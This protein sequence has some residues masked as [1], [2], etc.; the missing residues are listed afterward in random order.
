MSAWC[1]LL[2]GWCGE[3]GAWNGGF[4]IP[5]SDRLNLD[6]AGRRLDEDDRVKYV[7]FLKSM[8]QWRAEDRKTARELL[9]DPW[10]AVG[11]A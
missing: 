8:L 11:D 1:I 4:A 7:A 10:L 6:K 5:R 2:M 3:I 9:N